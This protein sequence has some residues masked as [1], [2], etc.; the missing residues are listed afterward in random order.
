MSVYSQLPDTND[1]QQARTVSEQQSQVSTWSVPV[2]VPAVCSTLG[3]V[4]HSTLWCWQAKYRA[5]GRKEASSC[6]YSTLPETPD[7]RHAKEASELQSQV[8][9]A[10]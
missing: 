9:W 5:A 10:P 3:G 6:L 8:T 2:P 4:S 7:T 1:I